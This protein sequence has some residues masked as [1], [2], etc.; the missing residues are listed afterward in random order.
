MGDQ[1]DTLPRWDLDVF[2]PGLDSQA[3]QDEFDAFVQTI[4][5]LE[6][7]YNEYGVGAEGGAADQP[8]VAVFEDIIGDT[9][10]LL[11]RLETLGSYLYAFIATDASD[12]AAQAK[13]SELQQPQLRVDLLSQ[14]LAAW[15]GAL[16]IDRLV[17]ASTAAADHAY[18]LAQAAEE[19]QHLMAPEMEELA[20]SLRLT[21]SEA[22]GKLHQDVTSRIDVHLELPDGSRDLP[23]SAVRNLAYDA[24][25]DTRRI[26]YEVELET[27]HAWRVPLAASMNSIKGEVNTLIDRRSWGTALDFALFNNHIDRA[28]LDAMMG[29]VRETFPDFRRYLKAKAA[30]LGEDRLPWYDLFAPMGTAAPAWEFDDGRTFILEQFGH[31]SQRLRGLAERAFEERWIDA[32][33]RPGKR[34]GGFCMR[35]KGDQSRIM[36]NYSASYDGMSTIAHELGHAYHNMNLA[37][38]TMLQAYTPMTLA[39]TASTFCQTVIQKAAL[40]QLPEAAQL[41]ILEAALQDQC[42]LMVDIASRLAF[43]EEVFDRRHERELSADELCEIML[44]AQRV[45]YGDGLDPDRLHAYMWAVKPHYYRSENPFY[46]FPYTFGQLFG[47]GLFARYQSDPETFVQHYDDLLS[48][49]GMAPAAEL[50]GRFGIDLHDRGFW[51]A[52]LD[53][54]REDIDRFTALA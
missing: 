50:A 8:S 39:E 41:P 21:G 7:T 3:F 5:D 23:M 37:Q 52:S 35:V 47:L 38:R 4:G 29:A 33:P 46:N 27:W 32:E 13:W 9:N 15:I 54:I 14:R 16:D 10:R 34:D 31:F 42:Q 44:D 1:T 40:S 12:D 48:A 2:F 28:T 19:A 17:V 26:A 6:A 30:M 51:R 24:D 43:E 20:A 45:T 53:V 22:W 25:R 49:T 18:F 11:E 36:V